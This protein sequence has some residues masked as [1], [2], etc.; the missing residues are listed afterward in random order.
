[1][2]LIQLLLLSLFYTV[3]AMP[4]CAQKAPVNNNIFKAKHTSETI[5]IDGQMNESSWKLSNKANFNHHYF[6]EKESD[7]QSTTFRML[8]D[9]NYL[10]L[11]YDCKDAYIT[12]REKNRD[13]A[14][15][16]DD[17]AEIF[18]SPSIV[19]QSLH[20]CL[21]INLYEVSND[22]I[23][24]NNFEGDKDA[25]IKA[26]N[27]EYHVAVQVNG[28]LNDNSDIDTG[29]KMELAIPL[30]NFTRISELN[31]VKPGTQWGFLALRQNRDE[32]DSKRRVTSIIYPNTK[33]ENDVHQPQFFGRVEFVAP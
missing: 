13:G 33:M 20:F 25:V 6:V 2:K 24:L 10:Y 12:A 16:F 31:P 18:L 14:T 5:V 23:Y 4:V 28:T 22:V 29:W 32:I 9:E 26:F 1:M 17:C 21:E 8:W 15:F 7:R 3:N 30:K 11:F 27:P 19:N